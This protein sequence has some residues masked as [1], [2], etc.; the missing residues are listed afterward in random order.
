VKRNPA[1]RGC[2]RQKLCSH[3]E[4]KRLLNRD[5]RVRFSVFN[6]TRGNCKSSTWSADN[7]CVSSTIPSRPICPS[8]RLSVHPSIHPSVP[9][10][11]QLQ[12]ADL[13]LQLD[14]HTRSRRIE[15][16]V[17]VCVCVCV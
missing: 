11:Q 2:G 5:S 9:L 16:T 17:C 6:Q 8:V 14:M 13:G 1:Q 10:K 3:L 4:L 12:T 15:V 7:G